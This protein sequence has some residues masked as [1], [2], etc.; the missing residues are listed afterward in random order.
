MDPSKAN[1]GAMKGFSGATGR[2][3]KNAH[4]LVPPE[5]AERTAARFGMGN[6]I[7]GVNN[8]K[9]GDAE[10]IVERLSHLEEHL[11]EFKREANSK[12]DNL[13]AILWAGY[14]LAWYE[15]NKPEEWNKAMRMIQG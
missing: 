6:E 4:A 5:G 3:I 14:C 13:G 15:A 7:Y 2:K 1:N 12:D 11:C 8:W 10:Y 9:R